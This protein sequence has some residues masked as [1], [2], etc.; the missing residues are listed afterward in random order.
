MGIGY[1]AW[2]ETV[3]RDIAAQTGVRD[4]VFKPVEIDKSGARR[5]VGDALLWIGR[6][7]VV[8]AI[9]SRDPEVGRDSDL[10]R[11]SWL[12]KNINK[13]VRQINGTVRTLRSPPPGLVLR[14]ERG[15]SVPWRPA[16]VDEILGVV[17]VD[18][19]DLAGFV[20]ETSEAT[21]PT[22]VLAAEDWHLLHTR[23]WSTASVVEYISWRS[24]SGLRPLP[25]E[26][27][28]DVVAASHQAEA[29]LPSGTPF[30]VRP[31]DWQRAWE[32]RP[33]IFFG[34]DPDDRYAVVIDA[35]I[36]GAAE[37]DPLYTNLENPEDYLQLIEFLDRIPPFSRVELG[38]RIWQKCT[39]VGEQGSFEAV[40]AVTP[41]G[42]LI[43]MAD[44]SERDARMRRIKGLTMA[45]HTQLMDATALPHV[46][47]LGVATEG[48][49]SPGRSHDYVFIRGGVETDAAF[50]TQRDA[51]FGPLPPDFAERARVSLTR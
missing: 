39:S 30:E 48:T 14:S 10:R 19:P 21:V 38:K 22:I 42:L 25:F 33:D 3:V 29:D 49:P 31:G 26:A 12:V 13:A 7:L 1:G 32:E 40:L 41:T 28:R 46:V 37:Q 23:L 8:V 34:N 6:Q 5:E 20:P 43:V 2:L 51:L 24:R 44:A 50:R 15:V 18:H 11:D 27:E 47:T 36:A 16:L 4:F 35:I 9:K 17:V 45:R